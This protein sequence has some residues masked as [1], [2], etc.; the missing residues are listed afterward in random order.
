MTGDGITD[1]LL[2]GYLPLRTQGLA[3]P[4][5]AS[6]PNSNVWYC[7]VCSIDGDHSGTIISFEPFE[8]DGIIRLEA[9]AS[10]SV[11]VGDPWHD[12]LLWNKEVY[13]GAPAVII[14][15]F[16]QVM[17][18]IAEDIPLAL[19]DLAMATDRLD[20]RQLANGAYGYVRANWGERQADRWQSDNF[21]RGHLVI[22]ARRLAV[23][24]GL[25]DVGSIRELAVD[26]INGTLV[27]TMPDVLSKRFIEHGIL[28]LFTAQAARLSDETGISLQFL[29]ASETAVR[30]KPGRV[31]EYVPNHKKV[32]HRDVFRQR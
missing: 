13:V 21:V 6:G 30:S 32:Y 7:A 10:R 19:L 23:G 14:A 18:Q 15:Q 2:T 20:R 3:L 4:C 9:E 8:A 31:S 29:T 26:R 24:A 16:A 28:K 25:K 1:L 22:E 12:V 5:Y 27:V 11:S 17:D